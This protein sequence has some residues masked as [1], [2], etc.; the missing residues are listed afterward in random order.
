MT[1]ERGNF[2]AARKAPGFP[3]LTDGDRMKTILPLAL[4]LSLPGAAH[5][6]GTTS[7]V[8]VEKMLPGDRIVLEPAERMA[9]G[10]RLVFM[11]NVQGQGTRDLTVTNPMPPA[12]AYQGTTD[13]RA[14]VSI[15]GG[16]N[17]GPLGRL[18]VTERDGSTRGARPEDVTHVRWT[19]DRS[20]NP[21]GRI[22]FR[23]VVR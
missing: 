4:A 23:G 8:F 13:R 7:T 20:A 19:L 6:A 21:A 3:D 18:R 11:M 1:L 10:D 22:I 9:R 12:V 16:R 14:L 17:W 2:S 5:A 15:D